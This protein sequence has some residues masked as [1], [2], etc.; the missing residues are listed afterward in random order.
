MDQDF[1][2]WQPLPL[3]KCSMLK[4]EKV[5]KRLGSLQLAVPSPCLQVPSKPLFH[6]LSCYP[7]NYSYSFLGLILKKKKKILI[8]SVPHS[9]FFTWNMIFNIPLLIL[10][11]QVVHV[12]DEIMCFLRV[13]L[14][15]F[16][17]VENG[18]MK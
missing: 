12:L 1:E 11:C 17:I 6:M 15:F 3:L 14:I 16:C 13:L 5:H 18:F 4:D 10:S 7:A 2:R 9:C 8:H